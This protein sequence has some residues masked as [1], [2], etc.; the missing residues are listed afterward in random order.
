[1]HRDGGIHYEWP[2]NLGAGIA[3]TA[4]A[5]AAHIPRKQKATPQYD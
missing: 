2:F 3:I 4:F 5:I 1:M